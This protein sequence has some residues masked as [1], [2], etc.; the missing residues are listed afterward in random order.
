MD[1]DPIP[2]NLQYATGSWLRLV[3]VLAAVAVALGALGSMLSAGS[4][5]RIFSNG[6]FGYLKDIATISPRRVFAIMKLTLKEAW[7]RKALL[8]FV[9]FAMLL[10]FAGWFITD[11]NDRA[12]LQL[13]VHI[14]FMLTTISW[15]ILPVVMFLSCWGLPEDIRIRSLHTVVTKPVRRIEVVLGR[16]LG[17]VSMSSVILLVMGVAG[18]IWITR[19]APESLADSSDSDRRSFLTCRVPVYGNLYFLNRLGLP[20]NAGINVGDP[21]LHRSFVEGNSRSR[22]VWVFPQVQEDM[23]LPD[24]DGN[25]LHLESRFEAFRTIKGSTESMDKGLE[26]QFTL[27][28]DAREDAFSSFGVGPGFREIGEALRAG[29]FQSAAELLDTAAQ[30]MRD[31]PDD[32][33]AADCEQV[34]ISCIRQVVP[35]LNYFGEDLADVAQAFGEFGEASAAV[36]L[37][38]DDRDSK[39]PGM[40]DACSQ[41]AA[42]VR[43]GGPLMMELMP[44][45]E[46]PLEPFRVAEYH[47]GEEEN[48]KKYPRKLTYA[49]NY[50]GTARFLTSTF[51]ELEKAGKLFSGGQ[52]SDELLSV[53]EN[54]YNVSAINAELVLDVLSDQLEDGTVVVEGDKASFKDEDGNWLGLFTRL[55]REEKLI[56]QDPAGW[57]LEADL[58]DDLARNGLLRVEVSCLD[59]QMYLGMAR[60]DLFIRLP[61]RP[62][63]VGYGKALLNIGLM[64]GLVV[65][66]GVTASCVVKGP[67]SFFFTLAVFVIGQAFHPMMMR[68]IEGNEAGNGMVESAIMIF[69]HR[70]PNSGIDAKS[71][72]QAMVERVDNAAG[73]M[74]SGASNIIPDFSIFSQASTYIGNGFDVPWSTSI[75]PALMTFIGFFVPCVLIGAAC[76]KFRELEAK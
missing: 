50:E 33:P 59:D 9:V 24:K 11:Q 58:F 52:P 51:R 18:Y 63:W 64:L 14:T 2:Y 23:L 1:F 13:N 25:V 27:V 30:R 68:I 35:V 6:L 21:W 57:V 15:L 74:L 42:A 32:F 17:F 39:M 36:V 66:L 22:A 60:P 73:T 75:L 29:E 46:V 26:A 47:N 19:Q 71:S 54:D 45:L 43:K 28:S 56:S 10:M 5:G 55:V 4:T 62:F 3:G 37:A 40:A 41:L 38:G 69:Q 44:S 65:V 12:E 49:A 31:T 76:L 8:V 16:M 72:T 7:R 61:D 34:T 48:L 53:L 20:S 67:V 70:N